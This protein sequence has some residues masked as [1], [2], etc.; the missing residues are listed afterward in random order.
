MNGHTTTNGIQAPPQRV[1]PSTNGH[2]DPVTTAPGAPQTGVNLKGKVIA[3]TGANR[4]IGLGIAECCLENGAQAIYSIDYQPA[5]EE[6]AA[7]EKSFPG[8]ISAVIADIRDEDQIEAAVKKIVAKEGALHGMVCNAGI[9]NHKKALDFTKEEIERLFSVNV[10]EKSNTSHTST[11]YLA[12][13]SC[14]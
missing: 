3:I 4:G 12:L 8:R 10:R 13:Q 14:T 9:T 11:T 5:G 7:V 2:V 1:Q 6:L